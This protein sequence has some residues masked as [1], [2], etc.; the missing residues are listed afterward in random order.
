MNTTAV[1]SVIFWVSLGLLWWLVYFCYI[2]Y[3]ID[4]FRH[5]LFKMRAELFD[6]ALEG[7][8]AFDD[9]AYTRMRMLL[10]GFIRNAHRLNVV[11]L[12][13]V[14]WA[15]RGPEASARAND[16][17]RTWDIAIASSGAEAHRMIGKMRTRMH[18]EVAKQAL[19]TSPLCLA[20]VVPL[21]LLVVI[22]LAMIDAVGSVIMRFYSRFSVAM[23]RVLIGPLDSMAVLGGDEA[24]QTGEHTAIRA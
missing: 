3:R 20:T 22:Q 4:L 11:T 5:R 10:N 14:L 8:V 12:G 15:L 2:P 21:L 17:E 9:P 7:H 19:K 24:W 13:L 6:L 16:M 1:S 23:R 18:L